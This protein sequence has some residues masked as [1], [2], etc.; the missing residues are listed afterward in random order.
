MRQIFDGRLMAD[1]LGIKTHQVEKLG[2]DI[3]ARRKTEAPGC[4]E[5]DGMIMCPGAFRQQTRQF[6]RF[7]LRTFR[8]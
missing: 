3:T 6:I 8:K 7:G 1:W 5:C 4:F 2:R